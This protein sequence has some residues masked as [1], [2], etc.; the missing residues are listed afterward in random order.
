[1]TKEITGVN[2]IRLVFKIKYK[3]HVKQLLYVESLMGSHLFIIQSF[4]FDGG[5]VGAL[6]IAEFASACIR[7]LV[8]YIY[9]YICSCYHLVYALHEN[10]LDFY[11]CVHMIVWISDW[12]KSRSDEWQPYKST[13]WYN[14]NDNRE[15]RGARR[16]KEQL[17]KQTNTKR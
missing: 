14:I 8:I 1:M 4:S 16:A 9:I 17:N 11:M 12:Y 10:S 13:M 5:W 15:T 7:M 3:M 6:V 2:D